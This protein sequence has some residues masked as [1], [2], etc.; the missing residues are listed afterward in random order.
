[1]INSYM[2]LCYAQ[3]MFE[4]NTS[5][6]LE[7]LFMKIPREAEEYLTSSQMKTNYIIS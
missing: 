1:M 3:I 2:Q 7:S 5:L 4:N 6:I